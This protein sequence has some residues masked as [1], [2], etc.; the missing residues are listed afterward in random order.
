MTGGRLKRVAAYIQDEEAFC[1]TY[2]DGLSDVNIGAEHRIPPAARAP[3][4]GDGG[5]SAGALWRHRVRGRPGQALRREAAWRWRPDQRR[6]F[7]PVARGTR[8]HRRRRRPLGKARLWRVW[9][10]TAK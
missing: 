10:P 6:I 1:F 2:G 5:A 7:R 4:D 8:L 9:P 3:S